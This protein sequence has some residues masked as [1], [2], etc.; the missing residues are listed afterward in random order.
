MKQ[1]NKRLAALEG[2]LQS[3]EQNTEKAVVKYL[4]AVQNGADRMELD[5]RYDKAIATGSSLP[6]LH[7]Y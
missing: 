4:L 3:R 2:V 7:N 1:L 5:K 6:L